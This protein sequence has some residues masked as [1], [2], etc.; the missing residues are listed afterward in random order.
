MARVCVICEKEVVHG[1]PVDD[2]WVITTIR[3]VKRRLGIARNNE[4]VVGHECEEAYQKRR[5]SYEKNMVMHVIIAA[6]VLIVF[7]ILPI[8]TTGFSIGAVLV[9]ILLAAMIMIFTAFSHCP[10]ANLTGVSPSKIAQKA[11]PKTSARG[12]KKKR[13][14]KL[15]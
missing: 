4:L 8:F 11:Q 3:A 10:K 12:E 7:I 5:S 15:S 9:G 6:V 2:D 1:Y 13:K 14:R